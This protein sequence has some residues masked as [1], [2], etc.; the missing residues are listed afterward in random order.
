MDDTVTYTLADLENWSRPGTAL[1]V[2]GHPIRHSVSPAMHNAAL[3]WMA[4]EDARFADWRYDRFEVLPEDLPRALALLHAKNFRGVNLTVPHKILA[5]SQVASID[6]AAR[7]VGAVNTL[8][9]REDGWEGFNTDGYGLVGGLRED[10]GVSLTGAN[11]IL[12][13]AGGAARGAAVECLQR[14][15]A[16]LWIANRTRSNLDE[17]L[18][19]LAPLAGE[20]VLRGFDPSTAG[21]AGLPAGA[22]VVNATS[23][24]LKATDPLP[25]DLG[26]L[27]SPCAVY[28]MIYNPAET[29]LLVAARVR[30]VPAANGLS[31]LVYQGARALEIWTGRAVPVDAMAAAARAAMGR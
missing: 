6:P 3:A 11:V 8:R 16:S 29:A 13:G 24:G 14:G 7:L 1:A 28:D 19:L 25:I 12:L 5:V 27:P 31:M 4:L 22:V 9:W 30:H 18:A 10:L 21:A 20:A 26:T 23:A 17:L 2:L 15:C